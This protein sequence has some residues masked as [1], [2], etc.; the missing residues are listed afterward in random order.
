MATYQTFP[1][2]VG[3]YWTCVMLAEALTD[4]PLAPEPG[5]HSEEERASLR[6][7]ASANGLSFCKVLRMIAPASTGPMWRQPLTCAMRTAWC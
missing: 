4:D 7:L 1:Q 3:Y 6:T 5:M 2:R